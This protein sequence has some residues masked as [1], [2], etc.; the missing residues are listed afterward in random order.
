MAQV[1]ECLH[2]KHKDLSSIVSTAKKKKRKKYILIS[3]CFGLGAWLMAQVVELLPRK[4]EALNSISSTSKEK[5]V[6]INKLGLNL[7]Q[8]VEHLLSKLKALHSIP[9]TEKNIGHR[10]MG[11]FLEI[12]KILI[13]IKITPY[14]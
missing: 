2:N 13:L 10:Y 11:L 7:A 6:K 14:F 1:V 8:V 4:H 5:K 12:V 3:Y 9:S